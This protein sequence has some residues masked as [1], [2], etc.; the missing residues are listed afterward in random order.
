MRDAI[1]I[2]NRFTVGPQPIGQE[3]EQLQREG[4]Q[5]VIN[6]RTNGESVEDK[7]APLPREEG[8]RVE[9]LGMSY[10]HEPITVE[11]LHFTQIDRLR[12]RIKVAP[13]PIYIH[14]DT[15]QRAGAVVVMHLGAEEVLSGEQSLLKGEERGYVCED[16]KLKAFIKHYCN[17]RPRG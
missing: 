10:H 12:H 4:F 7:D 14:D 6:L 11:A 3:F 15:G 1:K 2:S 13:E 8:H 9:K 16:E 17:H 5:S